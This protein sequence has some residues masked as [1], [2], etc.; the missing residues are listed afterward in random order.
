MEGIGDNILRVMYIAQKFRRPCLGLHVRLFLRHGPQLHHRQA[1]PLGE[2][3]DI[4][5]HT[6]VLL[7]GVNQDVPSP[8]R[9]VFHLLPLLVS[10][11]KHRVQHPGHLPG[12]NR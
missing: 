5:G 11:E 7:R 9:G 4:F 12:E 3:P 1:C 8:I 6:P 10:Q 2:F